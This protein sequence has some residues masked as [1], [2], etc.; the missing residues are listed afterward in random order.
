MIFKSEGVR[1]SQ[2]E[3]FRNICLLG[4]C[5]KKEDDEVKILFPSREKTLPSFTTS[6]KK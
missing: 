4:K 2:E 3:V 6:Y 1:R 5:K